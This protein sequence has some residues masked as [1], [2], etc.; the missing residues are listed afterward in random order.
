MAGVMY[1][2]GPVR[3]QARWEQAQRDDYWNTGGTGDELQEATG[4]E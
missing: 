2:L 3:K 1:G 4:D